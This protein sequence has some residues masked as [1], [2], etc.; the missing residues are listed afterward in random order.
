MMSLILM[1]TFMSVF[2]V[3]TTMVAE[4]ESINHGQK[5]EFHNSALGHNITDHNRNEGELRLYNNN[6]VENPKINYKVCFK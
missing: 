2:Y 3:A 6:F 5:I 4:E 1:I